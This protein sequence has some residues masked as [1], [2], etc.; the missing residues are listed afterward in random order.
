M[1]EAAVEEIEALR[2]GWM[3]AGAR[4]ARSSEGADFWTRPT[5]GSDL[6]A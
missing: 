6:L 2:Y 1:P 4:W 5:T 3:L